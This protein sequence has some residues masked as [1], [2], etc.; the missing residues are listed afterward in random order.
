MPSPIDRV[1]RGLLSSMRMESRAKAFGHPV[2][3]ML[4]PIPLGLLV[5]AVIFDVIYAVGGYEG[6]ALASYYNILAGIVTALAAALFGALDWRAIPRGTR[7]FRIGALHGAGN[8]VLV[9]LF[10]VSAYLRHDNV[11]Y[12][13]GTTSLV[14]ELVA[15]GLGMI[16]GWLGGELVDRLG[17]GVDDG[18]N[19]D[20]P[21]SLRDPHR[22]RVT[23]TTTNRLP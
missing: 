21:S 13:P 18:A 3:Q 11:G 6:L 1:V 16:T 2:H 17:V 7:A 12:L 9:A 15:L 20:A 19:V 8:V 23:T 22:V 4:V 10:A 14:L 5:M